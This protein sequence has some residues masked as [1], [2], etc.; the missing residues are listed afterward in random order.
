[1]TT[2]PADLIGFAGGVATDVAPGVTTEIAYPVGAPQQIEWVVV[3]NSSPYTINVAQGQ[4]LGLVAAF[5]A[6]RFPV[7]SGQPLNITPQPTAGVVA[8]GS[9]TSV[10]TTWYYQ[11]PPG[12]YPSAVGSGATN[13]QVSDLV[14]NAQ[15]SLP[16]GGGTFTSAIASVAGF[17]ASRVLVQETGGGGAAGLVCSVIWTARTNGSTFALRQIVVPGNG[18]CGIVLPNFTDLVHV[19]LTNNDPT[20]TANYAVEIEATTQF[21]AAVADPDSG[22]GVIAAGTANVASGATRTISGLGPCPGPAQLVVSSD[23]TGGFGFSAQLSSDRL[24]DGTYADPIA[25]FNKVGSSVAFISQPVILPCTP[26]K[27]VLTN[28]AAV[29]ANLTW[30]LVA[31]SFRAG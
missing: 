12:A 30:G 26:I 7:R 1:M 27:L 18:Q 9:D 10:Y 29:A 23:Q 21:G 24:G 11:Q 15:G 22:T 25:W 6:D 28:G 5:T 16:N 20:H 3:T 13:I 14:L 8:A 4:L 2:N 17:A 19:F 31:D